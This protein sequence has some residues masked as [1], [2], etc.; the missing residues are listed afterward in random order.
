VATVV[1]KL[2]NLV[3][4]DIAVFGKKDY[5]QL[6]LIERMAQDL[7]IAVSIVGISTVREPDGLAMSSRNQYLSPGER[8]VAPALYRQLLTLR[9]EIAGG[10]GD[11][12]GLAAAAAGHLGA[13]GFKP[14]YVEIRRAQDLGPPQA[15][16]RELVALAAAYLGST[17]LID[18]LEISP[19]EQL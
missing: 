7:A 17:R 16:E 2:F 8:A 4:P 13:L 3:Q 9:D 14:Q 12:P 19:L 15:G 10:H 5:Q 11:F 1:A 18:N 6:R